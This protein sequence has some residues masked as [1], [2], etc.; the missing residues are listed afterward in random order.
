MCHWHTWGD[1]RASCWS[2]PSPSALWI[3]GIKVRTSGLGTSSFYPLSHLVDPQFIHVHTYTYIHTHIYVYTHTCTHIHM[4]GYIYIYI[5]I[6]FKSLTLLLDNLSRYIMYNYIRVYNSRFWPQSPLPPFS[7][8]Y[9][10]LFCVCGHRF[11]TVPWRLGE[12]TCG[13]SDEDYDCT[14]ISHPQSCREA[15]PHARLPDP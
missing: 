14:A 1:Q 4:H 11:G 10:L 12:F 9:A 6:C 2:W 5:L 15:R 3:L 7:H 8:I 13:S